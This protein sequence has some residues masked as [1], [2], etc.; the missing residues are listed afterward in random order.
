MDLWMPELC[1]RKDCISAGQCRRSQQLLGKF[2]GSPF[3]DGDLGGPERSLL[4][5]TSP[6]F[7]SSC[8]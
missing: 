7:A 3:K 2:R 6:D 8:N 1:A 5:L 4:A